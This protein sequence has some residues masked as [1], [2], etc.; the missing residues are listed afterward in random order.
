MLQAMLKAGFLLPAEPTSKMYLFDQVYFIMGD[1]QNIEQKLSTFTGHIHAIKKML[2]DVGPEDLVLLDELA[3][4]TEP[5][6][7]ASMAQAT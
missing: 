7:G 2:A 3:N 5:E 1:S 6:A 4:G